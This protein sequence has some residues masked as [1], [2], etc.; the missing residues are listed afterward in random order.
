M[1]VHTYSIF[2]FEMRKWD[3][4]I[5]W[6]FVFSLDGQALFT[7][8]LQREFCEENMEFWLAVEDYRKC[9]NSK[10]QT[11]AQQIY[12]DFIAPEAPKEVRQEYYSLL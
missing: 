4:N 9:R 10:L 7:A 6:F 11:K 1:Y 3:I 5:S 8:F 2:N 12:N